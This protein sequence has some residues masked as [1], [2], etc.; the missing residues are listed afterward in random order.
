MKGLN[1]SDVNTINSLYTV[2]ECLHLNFYNPG[3]TMKKKILLTA[4]IAG[5]LFGMPL[6][7]AHAGIDVRISTGQ[8]PS[9]I[10][11]APPRFIYLRSQGFSVSVESPYDIVFY[12]NKYYLHDD[13]RW[14]SSLHY[15]G[16]WIPIKNNR[17]PAKLRRYQWDDIGRYRDIEY[18]RPDNLNN[19]YQRN[20]ENQRRLIDQRYDSDRRPEQGPPNM[21][22]DRRPNQG[23][24]NNGPDMRPSHET[25]SK[26]PD[27]RP[28]Q[29]PPSKAPDMRPN[30]GPP[31]KAPDMRPNQGPPS[32]ASDMRPNQGPPSKAS[33]MRPNQ[34]PPS[35]APDMRPNQGPPSKASDMRPN[36][37]QQNKGIDNKRDQ[38]PADKASDN[39]KDHEPKDKDEN[40]KK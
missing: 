23:P 5:M 10:I 8:R 25:P 20:D 30:Q 13:G 39:R 32:K 17:L 14:Y 12:G 37:G 31:S 3:R 40:Y 9:F 34:G 33:D 16:P 35:K 19:K 28:N 18:R 26:A 27:M 24:P 6:V 15:R 2:T 11:D 21:P 36:Q 22:P 38:G 7:N 1:D 29:G 4:G